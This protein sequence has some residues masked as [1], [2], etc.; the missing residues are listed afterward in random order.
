MAAANSM[1]HQRS[2]SGVRLAGA[3]PRLPCS[4]QRGSQRS[5]TCLSRITRR[6]SPEERIEDQM[7]GVKVFL[8][9]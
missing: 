1:T 9:K 5:K 4:T 3:R 7:I 2:C 6:T 8:A